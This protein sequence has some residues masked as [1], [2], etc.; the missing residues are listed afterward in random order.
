M[1]QNCW[2]QISRIY[3]A[4]LEVTE[5]ERFHYL[6][7][8]CAGDPMLRAEVESLLAMHEQAGGFLGKPATR[9]ADWGRS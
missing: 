6:Q 7:R 3:Q 5:E 1:D 4:S 2:E 9:L 8:E